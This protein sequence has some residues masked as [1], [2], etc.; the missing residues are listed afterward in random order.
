[1]L[2]IEA[3]SV[4]KM[5]EGLKQTGQLGDVMK[6]SSEI[7]Y[8]YVKSHIC[9]YNQCDTDGKNFFETNK[10]HLHVPE[11]ATPKDGPSAGITMALAL[12][13]LAINKPVKKGMAMTGELTLTGKVLPIGGLKEKVIAARRVKVF[14]LIVPKAN[15]KDFEKLPEYLKKDIKVHYVDYFEDVIK[16]AF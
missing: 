1:T 3:I 9:D 14:E 10:I 12:Y 11:G 16:V 5:G 7:A 15:D 13:S 6:E 2:Y 4:S 8:S